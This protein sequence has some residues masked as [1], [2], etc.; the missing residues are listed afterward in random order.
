MPQ[1]VADAG[2]SRVFGLSAA[3]ANLQLASCNERQHM[4][5]ADKSQL[6]EAFHAHVRHVV[7]DAVLF[8][9]ALQSHFGVKT[10]TKNLVKIQT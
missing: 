4:R 2:Y 6:P 9:I 8:S 1:S 10:K 7:A 5:H 3:D